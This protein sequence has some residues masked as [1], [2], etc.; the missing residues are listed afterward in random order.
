M[1]LEW[2]GLI[3]WLIWCLN[4]FLKVGNLHHNVSSKIWHE[5]TLNL[6]WWYD[7]DCYYRWLIN[8]LFNA[9]D[10]NVFSSEVWIMHV[11]FELINNYVFIGDYLISQKLELTSRHLKL[12]FES[13]KV[14]QKHIKIWL[15]RLVDSLF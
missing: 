8:L 2:I 1:D 12:K 15:L 14:C 5:N 7:L 6:A 4:A 9:L 3:E 13:L 11:R 10:N